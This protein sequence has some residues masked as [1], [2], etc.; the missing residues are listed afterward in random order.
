MISPKEA[1]IC[2]WNGCDLRFH[3]TKALY[4]HLEK[5]HIENMP[6]SGNS[7]ACQWDVCQFSTT[8]RFR[9]KTHIKSH[10]AYKLY[11]CPRPSCGATF[12]H[13]QNLT[14]HLVRIHKEKRESISGPYP[15]P[16]IQLGE[17]PQ[18]PTSPQLLNA[19]IHLQLPHRKI[20]QCN[21]SSSSPCQVSPAPFH[22]L[23]HHSMTLYNRLTSPVSSIDQCSPTIATVDPLVTRLDILLTCLY[24]EY[25]PL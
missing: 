8:S 24:D 17:S 6:K 14:R 10:V 11:T 7:H 12:K 19:N 1:V 4:F 23:V 18:S 13:K 22:H 9:L 3:D 20:S 5:D 25:Q 15:S 2:H 16:T 21:K